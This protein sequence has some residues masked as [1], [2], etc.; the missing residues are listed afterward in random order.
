LN[1][2]KGLRF[3]SKTACALVF[4]GSGFLGRSVVEELAGR[5]YQVSI[6]DKSEPTFQIPQVKFIKGDIL[7]M[8]DC[9]KACE[10][11]DFVFN[12]AGLSDINE[13]KDLPILTAELNIMGHAHVLEACRLAKVKRIVY[14]S[15]VYVYSESGSFYRVSKQA[16]E[17]YTELYF[18]QYGL[19]FTILRYGSLYGPRAD[20]R[21]AIF[22]FVDSAIK[23]NK[24]TYKGS[25]EE[26][27]EYVHVDDAAR[28]SVDILTPEHEGQHYVITGPQLLRVRDVMTM[29]SEMFHDRDVNLEFQNEYVEAHYKVTPYAYKPR[30]GKKIIVN[31]FID[32]GQGILE[33]IDIAFK[34]QCMPN[35]RPA[36]GRTGANP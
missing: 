34:N 16:G 17:K 25:G 23:H 4:G 18:E 6:F 32:L 21:N 9:R 22:R 35:Q 15:S 7:S 19:P 31:P 20:H 2:L 12:F 27:R 11:V 10:G 5:G 1:R 26:L 29:I 13:A 33:C 14:A 24:I 3:M 8:D 28:I 30:L 36:E